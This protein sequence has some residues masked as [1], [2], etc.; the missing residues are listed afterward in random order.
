MHLKLMEISANKF[1]WQ[2]IRNSKNDERKVNMIY[3][4]LI[5][6]FLWRVWAKVVDATFE[7]YLEFPVV[8]TASEIFKKKTFEELIDMEKKNEYAVK[9]NDTSTN[10]DS[11]DVGSAETFD[12]IN[13]FTHFSTATKDQMTSI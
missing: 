13:K 3:F 6:A 12:M 2:L 1:D 10:S 9:L 8:S 11:S 7:S 5:S 4:Y